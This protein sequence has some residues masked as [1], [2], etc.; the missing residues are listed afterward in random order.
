MADAHEVDFDSTA[1]ITSLLNNVVQN[2]EVSSMNSVRTTIHGRI[3]R[4]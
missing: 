4:W 3:I 1:G 2:Y